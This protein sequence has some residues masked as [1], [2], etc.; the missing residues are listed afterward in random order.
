[1][2]SEPVEPRTVGELLDSQAQ[3]R[4][5]APFLIAPHTDRVLTFDGLRAEAR[6]IASGLASLGLAPGDPVAYLL[7]NGLFSV[8]LFLGAQY[9]GFVPVP[10]GPHG[11]PAQVTAALIHSGARLLLVE[12]EHESLIA[13]EAARTHG[14]RVLRADA[15]GEHAWP[16]DPDSVAPTGD[17]DAIAVLGYTSGTTGM[18]RGVLCSHRAVLAGAGNVVRAHHLGPTDRALCVVPLS[19][20]GPQNS[21]LMATLLSGGSIVLPRRFDA[22]AF[23]DLVVRYRCTWFALVPTLV[24]RLVSGREPVDRRTLGH[25]RFARSSA[26]PLGG[27]EHRDF[28]ARFGVPLLECMGTTEAGSNVF[29][30]PLPPT[31][32]KVGSVG[33][34]VG[35]DVRIVDD[36]GRALGAGQSGEILVRGPSVM[37]GY[38]RD[39]A[40]TAQVLMPDGWLCTGDVGYLDEDGY[41]FVVGRAQ[42]FVKKG[43]VKVSLREIDEA[44]ARHPAVAAAAAIGVPDRY[45]GEEL[46]AFV[47][48]RPGTTA[49]TGALLSFCEEQVGAL[50]VPARIEL[51]SELPRGPSGKIERHRLVAAAGRRES[52]PLPARA[53]VEQTVLDAFRSV[54]GLEHLGVHDDFFAVG[55]HSLLALRTVARLRRLLERDLPVGL[56]FEAPTAAGLSARIEVLHANG[57]EAPLAPV[58]RGR[59]LPLAP[60]QAR[61]WRHCQGAP[62]TDYTGTR[63]FE[64]T[65]AVDAQALHRSLSEIVRRH[66]ILR[67]T[68]VVL[69]GEP[70]QRAAPARPVPLPIVDVSGEPDPE[71]AADGAARDEAA[72][73]MDP[74]RDPLVRTVLVRLGGTRHRLLLTMHHLTF[75]RRSM[76]IFFAELRTLYEVFASGGDPGLP[77]P[78]LQYA[79]YAVWQSRRL[80]PGTELHRRQLAYWSER[81][82][83][84]SAG[85]RLPFERRAPGLAAPDDG[86][87]VVTVP[88]AVR[89]GVAAL[90]RR[91]RVTPFMS[92]VAALAALLHRWTGCRTLVIGTYA[93]TRNRPELDELMGYFV[94]LLLLRIDVDPA[95][96]FGDL[97]DHV[98]AVT[99][100]A[101]EHA[102]LV[103]ETVAEALRTAGQPVPDVD[104]LF[105]HSRDRRAATL[106]LPRLETRR[107]ATVLGGLPWNLSVVTD[108]DGTVTAGFDPRRYDPAGVQVMLVELVRLVERASAAPALRLADIAPPSWPGT[109]GRDSWLRRAFR[110]RSRTAG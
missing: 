106:D 2:A 35:F 1:M 25:V 67:T 57:M 65:G 7:D 84:G 78:R 14:V 79:D 29:S 100:G 109:A 36:T 37:K 49:T 20:R 85:L 75:D 82:A 16:G 8:A 5:P 32:R 12:P 11:G 17:P 45:V 58:P 41:V 102:D 18:P 50:K 23:W 110:R 89:A 42:E 94:N 70:A 81:L 48:L 6:R 96:A 46:A 77:E 73:G 68:Y 44:L 93:S 66:E 108:E 92:W 76:E 22:D 26:A 19:Q 83:A 56:L 80:A 62:T 47:V 61:V 86:I 33:I 91:A 13:A 97:L 24:A 90:S 38:H 69:D 30:T 43:G 103:F 107:L 88:A 21:T 74:A 64:L 51:V 60:A 71:E 72:R 31:P 87:R 3:Q 9:G 55:G 54:L 104:L 105:L 101:F 34:S 4:G 10:L 98:R 52:G 63:V 39:P 59:P 53:Q 40:A 28:E 27:A 95:G 99:L 15:D